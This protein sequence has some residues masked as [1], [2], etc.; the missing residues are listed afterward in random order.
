M[1]LMIEPIYKALQNIKIQEKNSKIVLM[2]ARGTKF[3]Q[4]KAKEYSKLDQLILICGHYEGFDERI[5][6][7]LVDEAISIGDYVLTGGEIPAIVITDAVCRLINGVLEKPE[8][9]LFESFSERLPSSDL[10]LPQLEHGQYTRP[11][12]FNGWKVPSVLLSGNHGEIKKWRG[13]K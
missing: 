5:K 4:S 7:H 11:E 9:T 8:A 1:V 2:D 3:T 13:Q 12:E 10:S 6:E